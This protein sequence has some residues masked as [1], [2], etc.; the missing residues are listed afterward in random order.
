[1]RHETETREERK[2][3]KA[4]KEET[5]RNFRWRSKNL[6]ESCHFFDRQSLL[7][8]GSSRESTYARRAGIWRGLSTRGK[9]WSRERRDEKEG[10]EK[11]KYAQIQG[12]QGRVWRSLRILRQPT[13]DLYDYNKLGRMEMVTGK[14]MDE[15]PK[16]LHEF[17]SSF[18]PI[19]FHSS[20]RNERKPITRLKIRH[21]EKI[22]S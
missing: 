11:T 13:I 17:F 2:E 4:K 12:W 14:R 21:V 8:R 7:M 10:A 18:P 22:P 5:K 6:R 3:G 19:L 1:M 15:I 20:P 16:S 9:S